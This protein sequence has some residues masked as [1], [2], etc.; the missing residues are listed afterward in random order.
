MFRPSFPNQFSFSVQYLAKHLK[1][2]MNLP[3]FQLIHWNWLLIYSKILFIFLI[4]SLNIYIHTFARNSLREIAINKL[5]KLTFHGSYQKIL[6]E[7]LLTSHLPF[8]PW[9]GVKRFLVKN[10]VW[11]SSTIFCIDNTHYP[12]S[13]TFYITFTKWICVQK[14]S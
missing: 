7:F 4:H 14:V 2:S 13:S 3:K 11:V 5:V 1:H 8:Y 9:W 10:L 6:Y 12:I